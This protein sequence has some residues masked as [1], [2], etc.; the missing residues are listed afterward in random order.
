M[1]WSSVV[2]PVEGPGG[3]AP[4]LFQGQTEAQRVEKFLETGPPHPTPPPLSQG[5]DLPLFFAVIV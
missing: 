4:L 2:D 5:P 3:P 1:S